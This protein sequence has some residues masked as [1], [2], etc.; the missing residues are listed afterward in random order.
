MQRSKRGRTSALPAIIAAAT[1]G[2][3]AVAFGQTTQPV[4]WV[5]TTGDYNTAGQLEP[6][7]DAAQRVA[8]V[9]PD[10]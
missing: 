5:G 4:T 2:T 1:L 6:Q 9:S 8:R 3:G 10:Q 7:P